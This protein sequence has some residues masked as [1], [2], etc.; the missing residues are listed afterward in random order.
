MN[1]IILLGPAGSGKGTQAQFLRDRFNYNH[2]STGD[3]L[4]AEVASESEL[5]LK[6]KSVI[7]SGNLVSDDIIIS[8][9]K[10]R[11]QKLVLN[12]ETGAIFDGFPRTIAQAEAF[13]RLL[14]SENI[15]LSSVLYFDLSLDASI[16]R[17]SGR[18]IDSRNNDVYHRVSK[19]APA[20]VQ[21]Y[22]VTRDDDTED[23]VT[24]RYH[25][26]QKETQPLL[27]FYDNYLKRIDCLRSIEEI[28]RELVQLVESFQVSV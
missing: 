17:I 23:K 21:P 20:D 18:Q 5:G 2:L 10:Q 9:I 7:D 15:A 8:I 19:P 1:I 6:V 14:D 24:H 27:T 26:Y 3:M 25:V 4:R 13:Q 11:L 12:N 16:E 28:N 22:L